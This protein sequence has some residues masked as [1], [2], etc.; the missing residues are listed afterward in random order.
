MSILRAFKCQIPYFY[1]FIQHLPF[2]CIFKIFVVL[3]KDGI[4][5]N[6]TNIDFIKS[7]NKSPFLKS[8]L[9]YLTYSWHR[10]KTCMN[11]FVFHSLALLFKR[12][13]FFF[14]V[15]HS[16]WPFIILLQESITKFLLFSTVNDDG[17]DI[18]IVD[19][20]W[21]IMESFVATTCEIG[22]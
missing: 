4:E 13:F 15:F 7:K 14:C 12:A 5:K 16:S 8:A 11:S 21:P 6:K 17:V 20:V 19:V 18:K 22:G 1:C 3:L 9:L 2:H 10:N